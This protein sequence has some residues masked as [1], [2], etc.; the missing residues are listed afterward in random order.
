MALFTIEMMLGGW[1]KPISPRTMWKKASWTQRFAVLYATFSVLSTILSPYRQWAWIGMSRYEGMLTIGL[2]CGAFLCVSVFARPTKRLWTIF[3]ISM[4]A[5]CVICIL[6]MMG[7]NPFWLY[8][9]GL[10][11]FDANKLYAGIYLGTIG[12][13]D[14]IAS[15][16]CLVIPVFLFKSINGHWKLDTLM[17][18]AFVL[19]VIVLIWMDIK[20]GLI[21]IAVGVWF[22]LPKLFP[23]PPK[24]RRYLWLTVGIGAFLVLVII[25]AFP[26]NGILYEANQLLHGNWDNQFGSGR[27]YIW[28]EVLQRIPKQFLFGSGPDT[29]MAAGIAGF[30]FTGET[31][32]TFG[33]FVDTAHNEYLNVLFH[34]GVFAMLSFVAIL[35]TCIGKW[36]RQDKWDRSIT[37]LGCGILCYCIQAMFGLSMCMT[38][39]VFWVMLGMLEN[40]SNEAAKESSL[41]RSG[42][43][44]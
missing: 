7:Y 31:G 20:A 27:V 11:Y 19:S 25:W 43:T 4:I 17:I 22:S 3:A 35:M 2:Y 41:C 5:F 37:G 12:N 40:I 28:K 18:I 1:V 14:L 44:Y 21:G 15:L 9:D 32:Q 29:M 26:F 36:L 38:A 8:P 33:T 10:T 13:A 39:G 34:Q 30:G 16:L 24:A 6:Q 42:N 23:F